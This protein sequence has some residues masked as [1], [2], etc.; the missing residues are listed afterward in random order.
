MTNKER[1]QVEA[2]AATVCD[3]VPHTHEACE[4]IRG[5]AR[6]ALAEA[7]RAD[8]A[9]KEYKAS[10]DRE[11]IRLISGHDTANEHHAATLR[12]ALET[13]QKEDGPGLDGSPAGPCWCIAHDAL[14]A[15]GVWRVRP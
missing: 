2:I 6:L 1:E 13:I 15:A 7:Q 8:W 3:K 4:D 9:E 12:A 5:L 11:I 14:I 10:N